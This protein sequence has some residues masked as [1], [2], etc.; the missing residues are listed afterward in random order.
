MAKWKET[1]SIKY[2]PGP[3]YADLAKK[4]AEVD[5]AH[6]RFL[7]KMRIGGII[8]TLLGIGLIALSVLTA[9]KCLFI[10]IMALAIGLAVLWSTETA[11]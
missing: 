4:Q 11:F 8:T 1:K 5:K 10:G 9:I 2:G 3:N 6:K 7:L